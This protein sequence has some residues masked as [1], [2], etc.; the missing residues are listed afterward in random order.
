M[1]KIKI[2]DSR[3]GSDKGNRGE[4]QSREGGLTAVDNKNKLL[5]EKYI[6]RIIIYGRHQFNDVFINAESNS[7][8][9]YIRLVRG[10]KVYF[11]S[12]DSL[13]EIL[14]VVIKYHLYHKKVGD[15]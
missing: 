1:T 14:D 5:N 15:V 3:Q 12:M 11:D 7:F 9:G 13:F 6:K 2:I 8:D 4:K 10:N